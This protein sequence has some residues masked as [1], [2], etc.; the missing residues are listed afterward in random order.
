M[1]ATVLILVMCISIPSV[2]LGEIYSVTPGSPGGIQGVIDQA[3]DGDTIILA[4]GIFTGAENRNL[5]FG[6]KAITVKSQ[7]DD[8]TLCIIDCEGSEAPPENSRRGFFFHSG[9]GPSSVVKGITIYDGMAND[10]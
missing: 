8:P 6:G 9:E 4:N 3:I 2:V 5:D 7:N 1:K 10:I